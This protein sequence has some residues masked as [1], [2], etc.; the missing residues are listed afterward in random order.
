M[1][2]DVVEM[3]VVDVPAVPEV[4][5][6]AVDRLEVVGDVAVGGQHEVRWI[7]AMMARATESNA[8]RSQCPGRRC[9]ARRWRIPGRVDRHEG[10]QLPSRAHP[11]RPEE[12]GGTVGVGGGQVAAVEVA[13]Q[14]GDRA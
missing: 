6:R 12:S 9:G 3:L 5:Q 10:I 14:R 4:R 7:T 11:I 13:D 8:A 2:V 1:R